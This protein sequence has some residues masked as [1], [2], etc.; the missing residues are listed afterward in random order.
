MRQASE[1]DHREI[2]EGL[3]P[4]RAVEYL[5]GVI[6]VLRDAEPSH[7]VADELGLGLTGTELRMFTAFHSHMG[8]IFTKEK[9]HTAMYFDSTDGD[10]P[11]ILI[12]DAFVCR[13]R[14]KL[15]G[16]PYRIDTVW[17]RGYSMHEATT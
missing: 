4:T 16:S 14:Q 7:S 17:G 3:P 12:V 13:L 2:A 9:M 11:D 1:Q 10:T 5:L 6:E 8:V 15:N